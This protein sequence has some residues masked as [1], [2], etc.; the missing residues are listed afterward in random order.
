MR[1]SIYKNGIFS[2]TTSI[3]LRVICLL[4]L[5]FPIFFFVA[6][7][8]E[9]VDYFTYVSELRSNVFL[10][11]KEGYS[12]RIFAVE[13]EYPY[14]ADGVKRD[15]SL[16]TEIHFF[17]P[18]GE[19]T[20]T[21]SFLVN[22]KNYGGEMSYDNVKASYYFSCSLDVSNLQNIDCTITYGEE[23]L[24]FCAQSV[25]TK[26]TLSPKAILTKLQQ[27]EKELFAS[28]TD[29]YGFAGEI[30]IRLLYEDFPYYYVGIIDRNGQI[31]AFLMNG[32]TGKILA[33]R[34]P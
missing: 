15:T 34:L 17:A 12:L 30:Y 19:K 4:A 22:D 33:K 14:A 25:K 13:K 31:T 28:L 7:E 26:N 21:V 16:R 23:K 11:E 5:F 2:R 6:C 8:K 10:A 1:N 20:T 9:S 29:K 18:S 27:S 24:S 32:E 3:F